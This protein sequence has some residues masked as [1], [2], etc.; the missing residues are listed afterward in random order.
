M[1]VQQH[2]SPMSEYEICRSVQKQKMALQIASLHKKPWDR[3]PEGLAIALLCFA[4]A[5][6][7]PSVTSGI[8][9]ALIMLVGVFAP[10]IAFSFRIHRLDKR[11]ELILRALETDIQVNSGRN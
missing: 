5:K 3:W 7:L 1:S 4:M 6:I 2:S 9:D 8:T 11:T 10:V